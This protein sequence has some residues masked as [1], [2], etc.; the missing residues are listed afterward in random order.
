MFQHCHHLQQA[1]V[2]SNNA[3]DREHSIWKKNT[4]FIQVC[5]LETYFVLKYLRIPLISQL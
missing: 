5:L 4:S 1:A 3:S 2:Y